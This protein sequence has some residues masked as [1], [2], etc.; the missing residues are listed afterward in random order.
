MHPRTPTLAILTA[1]LL[2]PMAAGEATSQRL[3]AEGTLEQDSDAFHGMSLSG[4][5]VG[6]ITALKVQAKGGHAVAWEQMAVTSGAAPSCGVANATCFSPYQAVPGTDD[7]ERSPATGEWSGAHIR[8]V[9]QAP[10]H[11][12]NIIPLGEASIHSDGS[13]FTMESMETACLDQRGFL[14]RSAAVSCDGYDPEYPFMSSVPMPAPLQ[15]ADAEHRLQVVLRGDFAIEVVNLVLEGP[16]GEVFDAVTR[17]AATAN[18]QEYRFV[19]IEVRD[20]VVRVQAVDAS[21]AVWGTGP[22]ATSVIGDVLFSGLTGSLGLGE[23]QRLDGE[24]ALSGSF[25][26]RSEPSDHGLTVDGEERSVAAGGMG[27]DPSRASTGW[28]LALLAA[29]LPA[30]AVYI[31]AR[32][33]DAHVTMQDVEEALQA[34]QY[35]HAAWMSTR[36]L[37]SRPDHESAHLGRGIALTKA[38]RLQDAVVHLRA[39]LEKN[40]PQD[41]TL[42]YV[43]GTALKGLGEHAEAEWAMGEA[44]QRTPA[45]GD[46]LSVAPP[47]GAAYT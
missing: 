7:E 2:L 29:L 47:D 12:I 46:Q 44:A 30:A 32:R 17:D 40:E 42:H 21:Q 25:L 27:P 39:Y 6:G 15:V 33:R 18:V 19:R 22:A 23:V 26:F 13:A 9:D 38:G 8:L 45:L 3:A 5:A 24:T 41:G 34:G 1:L 37:R 31:M 35:T 43:L 14:P 20:A 16:D 36:I 4:A 28:W 11:Q 10:G